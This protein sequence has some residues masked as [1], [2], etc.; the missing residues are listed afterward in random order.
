VVNGW[1]GL[2]LKATALLFNMGLMMDGITRLPDN[3]T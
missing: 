2:L 1:G 3:I